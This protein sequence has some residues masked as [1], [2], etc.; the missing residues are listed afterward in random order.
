[1][2][3]LL[4]G[5]ERQREREREGASSPHVRPRLFTL[6]FPLLKISQ[7]A[8]QHISLHRIP[9][10]YDL[11]LL[12]LWDGQARSAYR[13]KWMTVFTAGVVVNAY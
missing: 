2:I 13:V 4:G 6:R 8:E 7:L 3:C 1:M 11:P 9:S 12:L 10:P 5:R